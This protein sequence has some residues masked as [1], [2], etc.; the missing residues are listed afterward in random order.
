[1]I[2]SK[3]HHYA[4]IG[5]ALFFS[6][7]LH[8][9][10]PSAPGATAQ[11][12]PPT[13]MRD[14]DWNNVRAQ[15]R[16]GGELWTQQSG[17]SGYEAPKGSNLYLLRSGQ[18]WL[19]A[20]AADG[21]IKVAAQ[22]AGGGAASD[23]YPGPLTNNGSAEVDPTTCLNYDRFW[24]SYRS[25]AFRH[26]NYFDCLNNPDCNVNN[27]FPEGYSY[28]TYFDE[29]PA[30]GD[31]AEQEDFYLAPFFDYDSD[32][33]YDPSKGDYPWFVQNGEF[34]CQQ[35]RKADPI[36]LMGDQNIFAIFND[37][38]NSHQA[39]GG[40][41]LGVEIRAQAFA[42]SASDEINNATFYNYLIINQG[43]QNLNQ[44]YFGLNVSVGLGNHI[45]NFVGCDVQRGLAYAYNADLLDEAS[46]SSFGYQNNLPAF[47]VDFLAG[48]FQDEDGLD[49]PIQV[50]GDFNPEERGTPYE[51]LG[52][53]FG[54][55]IADNE[56]LGMGSFITIQESNNPIVGFP[57]T[58]THFYNYLKGLRKYGSAFITIGNGGQAQSIVDTKYLYPGESDPLHWASG[59]ESI[60][61]WTEEFASNPPGYR[62]FLSSTQAFSMEP[63]STNNLSFGALFAQDFGSENTRDVLNALRV[64]DD[65]A[66]GL[67]NQ[68][69]EVLEGPDAPDLEVLELDQEII[70]YLKNDNP[71]SNNYQLGFEKLDENIPVFLNDSTALSQADRSYHFQGYQLYQVLNSSV[72]IADLNNPKLSRLIVNVDLKDEVSIAYNYEFDLGLEL[73]VPVLKAQ[74]ENEGLKHTF[75]IK[76]DAF[77]QGDSRL[78][79]HKTYYF[80]AVAY[81]Y[82]NYQEYDPELRTG[83]HKQ[84]LGSRKAAGGG[85]VQCVAAVPHSSLIQNGGTAMQSSFGDPLPLTRIEGRGN[86][87]QFIQLE[88]SSEIAI[89]NGESM[90]ELKYQAG[91]GPIEV[92]VVD[93]LNLKAADF[94]IRLAPNSTELSEDEELFWEIRNLTALTDEDPSND[95]D[96]VRRSTKPIRESNEE[97]FLDWGISV[98]WEQYEYEDEGRFTAPLAARKIYD[99]PDKPWLKGL[100]DWN[101]T[102]PLN[103]IRG[104]IVLSPNSDLYSSLYNAL[105]FD[106]PMDPNRD[107][108]KLIEGTWGP[109]CLTSF[110]AEFPVPGSTSP[111]YLP[112]VAP[113]IFAMSSEI[114]DDVL[115]SD[116]NNVDIVFTNDKDLW[117]RAAVLEMQPDSL[118]GQD[119]DGIGDVNPTKMRL[120]RFPSVDKEGRWNAAAPGYNQEEA[121]LG[122]TQN[123]GMGWFPGYAIDVESGERLNMAFG[124]DSWMASDNGKDMLWNPSPRIFGSAVSTPIGGQHWIYVFRNVQ[125]ERENDNFM[126]AYDQ[127]AFIHE[128][129][130]NN[131]NA[132]N[133]LKVFRACTWVGSA[134]AHPDYP[135]LSVEEGIVPGKCRVQLRVCKPYKKYA[136]SQLETD[137]FDNAQNLWNPMYTF[138]TRGFEV[139]EQETSLVK[140]HLDKIQVVPNPYFAFSSYEQNS[141][142]QRVK[143]VNLPEE[144]TVS[145]YNL[146]GEKIRQYKKADPLAALDWDL[147]N[148]R[149]IPIAGGVYIIHVEVPGA[150][151]KVLKWFGMMR[152]TDLDRF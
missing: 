51:G 63:G 82:N 57:E 46:S 118:Y 72:S 16:L 146:N 24:V 128:N 141:L 84:Y 86:G 20:T 10:S 50:D 59:G 145:I 55:G 136:P 100:T 80:M 1:M 7:A 125:K 152:P 142:D 94:E 96:A 133:Q 102:T 33:V 107:Y 124:E 54:D 11:C 111:N 43:T 15:I 62:S 2:I 14:L 110:T 95:E 150:G 85:N 74:G 69:F 27:V 45:D 89:L 108:E 137:E 29:Y 12:A 9:K 147:K 65:K 38:G 21:S 6:A 61:S 32:G 8:S 92:Q 122:G 35:T 129:L 64:A 140:E 119:N 53:F 42:F 135:L 126:P 58:P 79:N 88:A 115:L 104:G 81:A 130:E 44:M 30:H 132:A 148:E 22:R 109:F 23:F 78:V 77:A 52:S 91:A 83:Q 98:K 48:P 90:N 68:C 67:F 105:P 93:P 70:L 151:E 17:F 41:A 49:N 4:A 19:G 106:A 75:Q 31:P 76:H 71:I 28:P 144:C 143:I 56:R 99:D 47:G 34:N 138:S 36:P 113:N 5:L 26:R 117:T 101:G 18:I 3:L 139:Q 40:E 103:W 66:Q 149:N 112:I 116:L 120:R 13:A 60:I 97:L 134:L 127:G 87:R 123:I 114:L 131:F 25:D 73:P 121:T 39:S 37:T